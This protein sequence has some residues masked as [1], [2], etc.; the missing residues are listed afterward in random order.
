MASAEETLRTWWQDHD[1][2]NGRIIAVEKKD[3]PQFGSSGIQVKFRTSLLL[4]GFR[5]GRSVRIR[6][7]AWPSI[8]PPYEERVRSM[9]DRFPSTEVFKN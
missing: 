1:G 2:M 8:K 7:E 4:E 9:E 3:N 6:A 5:P